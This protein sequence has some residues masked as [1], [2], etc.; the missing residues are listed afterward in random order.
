MRTLNDPIL[1][2]TRAYVNGVW[3]DGEKTFDV[4]NPAT[5]EVIARVP[6]LS[7]EDVRKAIDAAHDAKRG[8]AQADV[9]TRS[10][11]LRKLFEL[12][13]E[14]A[15]DLATILTA[16]MGKLWTEA[17]GE[18]LYGASYVEWFSK[19]AKRGYS[20]MIPGPQNQTRNA[21]RHD[22]RLNPISRRE[23]E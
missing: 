5:G 6:D 14:N 1:L 23:H 22:A 19:E 13:V 20:D 10:T 12:M 15:D 2:E 7:A 17:R 16:E 21:A 9:E 18:I 8:W 11:T 3:V 4:E